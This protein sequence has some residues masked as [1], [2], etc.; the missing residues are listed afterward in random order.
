MEIRTTK[1]QKRREDRKFVGLIAIVW[2]GFVLLLVGKA[3]PMVYSHAGNSEE[4]HQAYI[5]QRFCASHPDYPGCPRFCEANPDHQACPQF[6]LVHPDS[7]GCE[8]K[9]VH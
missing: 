2:V 7:P 8:V 1:E 5:K 9:D 3:I 4:F 6:C